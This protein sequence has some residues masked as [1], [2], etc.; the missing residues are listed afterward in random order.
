MIPTFRLNPPVKQPFAS[1]HL[2]PANE[3]K[4]S[5]Q[6]PCLVVNTGTQ[7]IARLELIFPI[8][9]QKLEIINIVAKTLFAGTKLSSSKVLLDRLESLGAFHEVSSSSDRLTVSIFVLSRM[10]N[11]ILSILEEVLTSAIFPEEE[12]EI[13]RRNMIQNIRVN[14]EKTSLVASQTFRKVLF[15][16]SSPLG[17]MLTEEDVVN[18]TQSECLRFYNENIKNSAFQI[19]LAGKFSEVQLNEFIDKMGAWKIDNSY[20][21]LVSPF[22]SFNINRNSVIV[23]KEGAMQAS[24]RV[25]RP[26]F[27]RK[28]PDYFPFL[29]LNTALGGYFG[30]RLMKNIREEKGLTYGISSSL[31]PSESF[32]YWVLG[33]DVKVDLIQVVMDEIYLEIQK[34]QEELIN[35]EE[36]ETVKK[37]MIGSFIGSLNTAFDIADKH[38]TILFNRLSDTYYFNYIS[39]TQGVT[40]E[41]IQEI[42]KKYLKREELFE[43]IVGG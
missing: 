9:A 10:L 22:S 21:G 17:K 40:P 32:G 13:Q 29:V 7:E 39:N 3:I 25:G 11:D 38:K 30:S 8:D 23:S 26:L 19:C 43:V 31:V 24:I 18:I 33:A 16:E 27:D 6:L 41:K 35:E 15:G 37:Y 34:I 28:H 12:I 5:N 2:P 20:T 4:L 36:L 14:A 42:S 1:F